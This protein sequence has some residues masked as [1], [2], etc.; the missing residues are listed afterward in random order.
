MAAAAT[1]G[2]THV[3]TTAQFHMRLGLA[4]KVM[5]ARRHTHRFQALI[6]PIFTSS[7]A[8]GEPAFVGATSE[9]E[10][11]EALKRGGPAKGLLQIDNIPHSN[12]TT[13]DGF[14]EL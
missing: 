11:A 2:K 6:S 5:G 12:V 13:H 1:H 4:R 10:V 7:F 9:W 3:V 8:F 14:F